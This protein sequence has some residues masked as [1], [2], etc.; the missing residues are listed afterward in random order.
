MTCAVETD[1]EGQLHE[2]TGSVARYDDLQWNS[3]PVGEVSASADR[4]PGW[5]R[6]VLPIRYADSRPLR[7]V[8]MARI[9]IAVYH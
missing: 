5:L 9:K 2:G 4:R 3:A 1:R 6:R 8:E 7:G